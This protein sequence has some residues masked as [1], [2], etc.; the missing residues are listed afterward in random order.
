MPDGVS[1]SYNYLTP[2]S[3][4]LYFIDLGD[5]NRSIRQY[6]LFED[7]LSGSGGKEEFRVRQANGEPR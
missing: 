1:I 4:L 3:A 6:D 7:V 2:N 5:F